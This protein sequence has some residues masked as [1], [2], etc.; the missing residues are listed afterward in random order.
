MELARGA[1]DVHLQGRPQQLG[2]LH[3]S[4]QTLRRFMPSSQ[5]WVLILRSPEVEDAPYE[6][7]AA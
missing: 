1:L 6:L 2:Y 7:P 3:I 5:G 4:T